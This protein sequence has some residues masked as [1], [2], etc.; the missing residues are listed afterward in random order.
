MTAQPK[1][2]GDTE[3]DVLAEEERVKQGEAVTE[4]E[5]LVIVN[6]CACN[7]MNYGRFCCFK[8]PFLF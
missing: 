7:M 6:I 4:S 1:R 3:E 5:C 8:L 2:E